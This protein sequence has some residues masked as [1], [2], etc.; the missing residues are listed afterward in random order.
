M[1]L[2][3]KLII[4]AYFTLCYILFHF[5]LFLAI[6]SNSNIWL[7]VIILLVLLV[8]IISYW[9]LFYLWLLMFFNGYFINNYYSLF[10]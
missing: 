1:L 2:L 10:Y 4:I 7:L 8:I 3:K 5:K 9:Y 6:L